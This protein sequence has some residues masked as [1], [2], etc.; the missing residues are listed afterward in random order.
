[1]SEY[2][3]DNHKMD[4][5]I[6]HRRNAR[7]LRVFSLLY[8]VS[9]AAALMFVHADSYKPAVSY[10][11]LYM[12]ATFGIT[13]AVVMVLLPAELFTDGFSSGVYGGFAFVVALEVFLSGGASSEL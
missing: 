7:T 13:A 12:V 3:Y 6:K 1:M 8:A 10:L 4:E 5:R 11:L 2:T 9:T